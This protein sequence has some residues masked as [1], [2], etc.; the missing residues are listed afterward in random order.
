MY[1]NKN[2]NSVCSRVEMNGNETAVSTV[3]KFVSDCISLFPGLNST[4]LMCAGEE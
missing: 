3:S 2:G 4:V 1:K